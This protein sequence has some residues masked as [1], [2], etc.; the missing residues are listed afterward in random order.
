MYLAVLAKF[1]Q[2][3]S[4]LVRLEL[5]SFTYEKLPGE[6]GHKTIK[7]RECREGFWN[8]GPEENCLSPS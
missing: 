7:V 4:S 6:E 1:L 2:Q 5:K 8:G 3:S